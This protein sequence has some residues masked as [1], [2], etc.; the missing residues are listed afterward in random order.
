M[1]D[2]TKSG[3]WMINLRNIFMFYILW[4][5]QNVWLMISSFLK[6][7]LWMKI[8]VAKNC[9]SKNFLKNRNMVE[10]VQYFYENSRR[11]SLI[12]RKF[13]AFDGA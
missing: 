4:I 9:D 2:I 5:Y 3:T 12:I 13:F 8:V 10:S 7:S 1:E 11:I 6:L